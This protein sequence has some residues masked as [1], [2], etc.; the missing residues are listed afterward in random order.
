MVNQSAFEKKIE[1]AFQL[2]KTPIFLVLFIPILKKSKVILKRD[3]EGQSFS[4]L[5]AEKGQ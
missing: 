2:S 5:L 1:C 4:M 3:K